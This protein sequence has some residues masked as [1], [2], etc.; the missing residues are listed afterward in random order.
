MIEDQEIVREFV[1][2]SD[3]VL[4]RVIDD[5]MTLENNMDDEIINRVFRA[6]HSI[7]GSARML[8]FDRL[9]EFGHKAEDVLS[10]V[11]TRDIDVNANVLLHTV[12]TMRLI[13]SDMRDG[14][15]DSRNTDAVI[16]LLDD[17]VIA[18]K[19][20]KATV[21]KPSVKEEKPTVD[22]LPKQDSSPLGKTLSSD[23]Y[24]QTVSPVAPRIAP[25]QE[26]AKEGFLLDLGENQVPTPV[27][28]QMQVKVPPLAPYSKPG[29]VTEVN[30]QTTPAPGLLKILIVEDDF[31][32]RTVLDAF[33]SKFGSCDVAKDGMEAIYAVNET[34]LSD[35]PQPYDLICM[36]IMMPI[37]DGLQASQKI[38]E[39]ERNN[40]VEG[41]I[42]ETAIVITSAIQDPATIIRACYESGANYYFVKPLDFNQ[43]KRQMQKLRLIT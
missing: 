35:P 18:A 2:E 20:A 16:H 40:G 25:I 33:L 32:C 24:P 23:E 1:D 13:L 21:P 42:H 9:G 3:E 28:V 36:D 26:K 22:A 37:M 14:G 19:Q 29:G 10:L 34:Y 41:T 43:M 8:G 27:P 11:R 4:A 39:I 31:T 30:N 7:K 5:I 6:F 17:I 38:R 15:D 12:D